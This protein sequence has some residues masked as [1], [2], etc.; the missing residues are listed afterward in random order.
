MDKSRAVD[1]E[2]Y[3][4]LRKRGIDFIRCRPVAFP[5]TAYM[6]W[7]MHAYEHNS[8]RGE[9]IFWCNEIVLREFFQNTAQHDFMVFDTRVAFVHDYDETGVI[10]GG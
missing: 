2:L 7:A 10:K 5:L 6:K 3:E 4:S 1:D 8:R 9:R